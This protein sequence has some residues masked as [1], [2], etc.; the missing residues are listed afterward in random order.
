MIS[1]YIL[2]MQFGYVFTFQFVDAITRNVTIYLEQCLEK[3]QY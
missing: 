3:Q 1:R 2:W